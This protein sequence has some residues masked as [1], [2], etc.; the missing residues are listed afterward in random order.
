VR[1]RPLTV[2]SFM[3][4]TSLVVSRQGMVSNIASNVSGQDSVRVMKVLVHG[5]DLVLV[6]VE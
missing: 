6:G 2:F 3:D 1:L 4:L 5:I